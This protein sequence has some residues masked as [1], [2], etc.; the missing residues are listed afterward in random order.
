MSH[1]SSGLDTATIF[2]LP[3][4]IRQEIYRLFLLDCRQLPGT[5]TI[6]LGGFPTHR[7]HDNQKRP[8]DWLLVAPEEAGQPFPSK[9][10]SWEYTIK[11]ISK[12]L[13]TSRVIKS[14]AEAVLHE[15]FVFQFSIWHS[16]AFAHQFLTSL[17]SGVKPPIAH[18][19]FVIRIRQCRGA[20]RAR[21]GKR[22]REWREGN[23][24][25]LNHLP[26]LR[27]VSFEVQIPTYRYNG[28][29]NT[30]IPT[31]DVNY[32]LLVETCLLI[33][34]GF[35]QVH[36]LQINWMG[37]NLGAEVALLCSKRTSGLSR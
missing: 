25:L 11:R 3:L 23:E 30:P 33:A 22:M 32:E 19:G 18:L 36:G 8:R 7:L 14:E 12:L 17:H 2:K 9:L 15:H 27:S 4:E 1:P 31:D 24:V 16:A 29:L 34:Y 10:A 6:R 35:M 13:L 26:C 37:Q 20:S 21:E 5:E 28:I